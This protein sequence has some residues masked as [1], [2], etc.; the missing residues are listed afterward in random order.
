M[1]K[2][3]HQREDKIKYHLIKLTGAINVR[4]LGGYQNK[5]GKKIKKHLLIRSSRLSKLTD[6]DIQV[7]VNEYN[8]GVDFDL[9][10]PEEIQ[11]SPDP[12]IPGVKYISSPVNVS[13]GFVQPM[14]APQNRMHYRTYIS[15][16][17]AQKTYRKLFQVLLNNNKKK[18]V[19]WHCTS[20]K[21]RTGVGTALIL[22]ALGFDM[23]TIYQDYL[24]SNYYLKEVRE[25][26]I[27]KMI[28]NNAPKNLIDSMKIV[29]GVDKTF[30]QSA[31]DEILTKFGS[32]DEYLDSVLSVSKQLKKR[33]QEMYLE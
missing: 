18:A 10:R 13:S 28:Q 5:Q 12:K 22:Y 7:L 24:N 14:D 16:A 29:G 2:E 33:L 1:V 23:E 32:V 4:D 21:D 3:N 27:A 6:S 26:T 11:K 20:G 19:L 8:L 17:Q 30:L 9:R 25:K 15:K 31:F